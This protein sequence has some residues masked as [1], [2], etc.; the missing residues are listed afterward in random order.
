[1]P[2]QPKKKRD[3]TRRRVLDAAR[4]VFFEVGFADA[5]LDEVAERA[6]VAKGTLYRY[7]ESK[8]DLYVAVLAR[9]AD[10]FVERMRAT[11]DPTLS[12]ED[13]IR[14]T[15]LFYF[16]HY[17]A[18]RDYFRIFWALENQRL[19]GDVDEKAVQHVITVWRQCLEI[20]AGEIERGVKEGVFAPC[21]PWEVANLLWIVGNGVIQSDLDPE[22]A[23]LRD[24][25][26][27]QVFRDAV[28]LLLRGLRVGAP[29]S[30]SAG[31]PR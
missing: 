1:V 30:L 16:R 8:A 14:A 31:V 7:F 9:N 28:E 22:R 12:A 27:E 24:R 20:L 21:D 2:R 17:D 11:I 18:H 3:E 13:Q 4:D 19:L 6:G 26:L 25:D 10:L 29:A 5:N 15:G 23:R